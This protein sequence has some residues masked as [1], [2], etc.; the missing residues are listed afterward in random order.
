MANPGFMSRTSDLVRAACAL[1]LAS[2]G[3]Q[4]LYQCTVHPDEF[5]STPHWAWK[6]WLT[7]AV[8]VIAYAWAERGVRDGLTRTRVALFVVQGLAVLYL[9]WLYPT[10]LLTS[11]TVIVAWQVAWTASLRAALLSAGLLSGILVMQKCVDQTDAMSAIILFSASGFQLFGI[12]VAHLARSE[13]AAR[14]RLGQVNDELIATQA[15]LTESARVS[16]R[17][18]ISRDLHDV[19]GHNLATLTIHLDVASRLT[20]GAAADHLRCARGVASAMLDEVR[21]VVGRVRVQ[22]VDLRA[23]LLAVTQGLT[24]MR[25]Q[26]ELP[27]DLSAIDPARAH[28]VLRCVQEAVTNAIRHAGATELIVILKQLPDGTMTVSAQDD[29]RGGPVVA[30]QGLTGMRDRFEALGGSL[31]FSSTPGKGFALAGSIPAPGVVR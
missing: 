25:V 30:G 31:S 17:L 20:E 6:W 8:L 18:D 15:L 7:Y 3:A 27:D 9:V 19:L 1:M 22:P 11:L 5:K 28:A 13:A 24:G 26:L 21:A 4:A 12:G 14:R 23:T 16:E 2:G 29:G 10:F